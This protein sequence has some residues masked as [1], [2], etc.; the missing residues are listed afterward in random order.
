MMNGRQATGSLGSSLRTHHQRLVDLA[1]TEIEAFGFIQRPPRKVNVP[2]A[3]Q[4][5][6]LISLV[7]HAVGIA[8]RQGLVHL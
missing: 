3:L 2:Q 7:L 8:R 4:T 6:C 5:L 1:G